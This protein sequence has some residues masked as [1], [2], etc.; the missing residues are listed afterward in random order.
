ML[1]DEIPVLVKIPLKGKIAPI[2][3]YFGYV[4]Q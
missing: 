2:Y 4:K 1:P 3:L